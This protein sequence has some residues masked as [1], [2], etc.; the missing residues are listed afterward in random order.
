MCYFVGN[1]QAEDILGVFHEC[2]AR[3]NFLT[4]EHCDVYIRTMAI[5]ESSIATQL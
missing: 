4:H 2:Y 3:E 5:V 1:Y